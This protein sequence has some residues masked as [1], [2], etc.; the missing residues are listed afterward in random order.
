MKVALNIWTKGNIERVYVKNADT[1]ESVPVFFFRKDDIER[2]GIRTSEAGI[3]GD[4]EIAEKILAA[5]EAAH[6]MRNFNGLS[7]A[8]QNAQV[9]YY[10][11]MK[12][13]Y[14]TAAAMKKTIKS[15]VFEI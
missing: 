4:A 5:V 11:A 7:L 6:G 8:C 9:M 1:G 2:G 15:Q 14:K 13:K 3:S 10:G 12:N